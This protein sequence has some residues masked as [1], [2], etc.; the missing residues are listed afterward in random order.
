MAAFSPQ[1][2]VDNHQKYDN[3]H[4]H[5]DVLG[6]FASRLCLG[7]PFMH[8]LRFLKQEE[9]ALPS[10]V[11]S[12]GISASGFMVCPAALQQG[13]MEQHSPWRQIYQLA[14]E[15]AKDALR[16]SRLEYLQAI[17]WN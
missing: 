10:A 4:N 8:R 7:I 11:A 15:Y 16:P 12:P 2:R 13:W 9:F 1:R 3:I 17:S 6:G 5:R 14:Y